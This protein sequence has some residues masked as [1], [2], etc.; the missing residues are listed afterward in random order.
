MGEGSIGWPGEHSHAH[1]RAISLHPPEPSST[2]ASAFHGLDSSSF[3]LSQDPC[4]TPNAEQTASIVSFW[5]YS[6]LDPTIVKASRVAHLAYEDFPP[7]CDYDATKN[8][9]KQSYPVGLTLQLCAPSLTVVCST[10]T[11]FPARRRDI[12]F[13]RLRG[14]SNGHWLYKSPSCY[15]R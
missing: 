10:W 9:I 11:R 5:T 1:F 2:Y 14:S 13:S 8:L 4:P 3:F 12:C 15:A 7:L 6:F